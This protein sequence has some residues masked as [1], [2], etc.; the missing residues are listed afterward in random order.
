MLVLGA[1]S[2][3]ELLADKELDI[4]ETVRRAYLAHAQ[5]KTVLPHSSFLRLPGERNRIIALPAYVSNGCSHAGIK[6]IASFPDNVAAGLTRAS[7]VI[8]LNSAK[9]GFPEAILEGSVISARRTAASAALAA[10]ILAPKDLE[11]LGLVGCGAI[12]REVVRFLR[13]TH[14]LIKE[15]HVFDLDAERAA[16]FIRHC[17]RFPELT[18]TMAPDATSVL[19]NSSVVSIATTA[20][21]PHIDH[22]PATPGSLILHISLRDLTPEVIVAAE[23]IVDDA[24]HVCREQTSLHQAEQQ[25]GNRD[26]IRCSISEL[27]LNSETGRPKNS[28]APCVFSPFGLGVLDLAVACMVVEMAKERK[29]GLELDDFRPGD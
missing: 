19:D 20:A 25:T 23:N 10:S 17:S 9:T 2:V 15:I 8:I 28:T 24:E 12:N 4:I 1:V 14:P 22:I 13:Q 6:W 3:R 11:V 5:G 26:F 7:A 16:L 27:L 21:K 18:V 29:I